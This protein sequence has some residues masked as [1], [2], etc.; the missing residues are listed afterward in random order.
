MALADALARGASG[1]QH[2]RGGDS[3]TVPVDAGVLVAPGDESALAGAL[4]RLL[5]EPGGAE[6]RRSL[7]AAARR[8]ARR[9]PDWPDA[10]RRF[11]EAILALT[12]DGDV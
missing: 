9:L 4:D 6:R 3:H 7:A 11:A 2:H 10:A 1:G 12:P 8:H 5:R